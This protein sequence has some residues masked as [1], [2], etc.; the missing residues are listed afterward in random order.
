[1]ATERYSPEAGGLFARSWGALYLRG[2]LA[3]VLGLLIL[4]RPAL[5][6]HLFVLWFAFYAI[7]EGLFSLFA[8]ISGWRHRQDRWL[9]LLETVIGF[10]IGVVTLRTPGITA[11]VLL[12]LIAAWAL[13]TGVLRIFEAVRF[14][15]E[16]AGGPWLAI[17]GVASIVFALAVM[18]RPM[19]GAL[20]LAKL[21]GIYAL[22]LG[23]TE[24]IAAFRLHRSA[25]YIESPR[26]GGGPPLPRPA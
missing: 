18:L 17:G 15:R 14:P 7:F 25:H 2:L 1:M 11:L 4:R 24:L 22:F 26:A 16:V 19:A 5:T 21:I 3:I 13:A 6:L 8:A 12:F 23:A 20:V 10:G 9:L